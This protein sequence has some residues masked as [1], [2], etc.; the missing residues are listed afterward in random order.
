M[1]SK[2]VMTTMPLLNRSHC[3]ITFVIET[4]GFICYDHSKAAG[5]IRIDRVHPKTDQWEFELKYPG[6]ALQGDVYIRF[7]VFDDKPEDLHK[8]CAELGPGALTIKY[9]NT[10]IGNSLCFVSFHTG[11]RC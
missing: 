1:L 3:Y 8:L 4:G 7:F 9:G 10:Y 5:A 2:I 6:I 11:K